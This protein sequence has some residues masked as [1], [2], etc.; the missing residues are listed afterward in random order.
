[1]SN[2]DFTESKSNRPS[3]IAYTVEAGSDEKNH[4]QKVGVAWTTK[5]DGLNV[6]L[7][8]IPLDGKLVLRSRAELE[9]MRAERQAQGDQPKPQQSIKP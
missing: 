1:M 9:R 5:N 8:S 7:N 2:D 3:H 4:W 6:Q